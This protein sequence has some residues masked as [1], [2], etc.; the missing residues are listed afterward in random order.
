MA[1]NC[2]FCTNSSKKI[3][4]KD[5][6]SLEKFIDTEAKILPRKQT[7]LCVKHQKKLEEGIKRARFLAL[8]PFVRL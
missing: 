1:Q 2:Y 8:L 5:A 6:E 4:Y 3:D 7:K